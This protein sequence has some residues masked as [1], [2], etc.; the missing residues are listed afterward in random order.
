MGVIRHDAAY[1]VAFRPTTL[2]PAKGTQ[3]RRDLQHGQV[4][5]NGDSRHGKGVVHVVSPGYAQFYTGDLFAAHDK[6]K[7]RFAAT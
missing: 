6:V 4:Q 3:C 5:R 2:H 7:R 1:A